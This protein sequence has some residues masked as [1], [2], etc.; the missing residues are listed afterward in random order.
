M[1]WIDNLKNFKYVIYTFCYF[2]IA[3][4][5]QKHISLFCEVE[6]LS[7]GVQVGNAREFDVP[8][9]IRTFYY[10]AGWA[11]LIK[12]E[13]NEWKPYG[14]FSKFISLYFCL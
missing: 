10:Y 13:L 6:A 9:V 2:S 4:Q 7:R 1:F 3:R 12:T 14:L 11:Q 5:L 8:A